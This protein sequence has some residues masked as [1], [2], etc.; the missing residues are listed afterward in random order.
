MK[1]PISE[2]GTASEGISVALAFCRKMNTTRMTRP[3]AMYR[4]EMISAMPSSMASVVSRD[5][6]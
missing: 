6:T 4:L 1:V 5:T 3:T 2:T